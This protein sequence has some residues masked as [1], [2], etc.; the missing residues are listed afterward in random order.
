MLGRVSSLD[1]LISIGLL[2][3]SFALTAPV[4]A[5]D[6]RAADA[7]R[8]GRRRRGD[9]PGRA[10]PA[11]HARRRARAA[12]GRAPSTR[13]TCP[14]TSSSSRPWCTAPPSAPPCCGRPARPSV[15]RSSRWRGAGCWGRPPSARRRCRRRGE[16][17]ER[18]RGRLG[19]GDRLARR[20]R[21]PRRAPPHGIARERRQAFLRRSAIPVRI[22]RTIR[23]PTSAVTSV[24]PMRRRQHLD[25][26]RADEVQPLGARAAR[27]EQVGRRH[28]AR[29]GG[30][31][32]G[33]EG[34]VEHVDVDRQER[35]AVADDGQRALERRRDPLRA[36]LVHRDR[37][38]A[39][40]LLPRELLGAGPVP[41][42]ADLGV[43]ARVDVAVADEVV[44]RRAVRELHAVHAPGRYRCGCRSGAGR[45]GR[46]ARRRRARPARRS[47]G[48]RRARSGSSPRSP[49]RRR[50]A[51]SRRATRPGR[52][53]SRARRR[54]RPPR[55]SAIA[56]TP[57]SRWGPGSPPAARIARGPWR[58]PGDSETSSSIGAPMMATSTPESSAASSV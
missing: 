22:S 37:G 57:V 16:L 47:S 13:P 25:H 8:R 42:Q 48:R 26:V 34:G 36:H 15:I 54:S 53:G 55:S 23:S 4:T 1:W 41:A 50:C 30:A 46:A 38:D 7:G 11:G 40:L 2:P 21:A 14:W 51:G 39:L 24:E 20:R 45:G 12:R 49:P 27:P 35:R 32:A 29:L 5:A 44:H 6:R 28:P 56:S 58:V 9:H 10:L 33:R 43:A 18:R 52:R 17:A 19:D 3:L 31:G